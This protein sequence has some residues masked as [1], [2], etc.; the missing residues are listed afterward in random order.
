[1]I[2]ICTDSNSQLPDELAARFG[3]EVVPLTMVVDHREYLEGFDFDVDD[4]GDFV[5]VA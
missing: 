4:F 1:M 3:I 2:G 5:F